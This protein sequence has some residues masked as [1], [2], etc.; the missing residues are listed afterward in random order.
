MLLR[1]NHFNQGIFFIIFSGFHWLLTFSLLFSA[2]IMEFCSKDYCFTFWAWGFY[3]SYNL[4]FVDRGMS[5]YQ[6]VL[7]DW[8][9]FLYFG[10]L[11]FLFIS[12]VFPSAAGS[13]VPKACVGWSIACTAECYSNNFSSEA[14]MP[15][16]SCLFL[17]VQDIIV[18]FL[19]NSTVGPCYKWILVL[20]LLIRQYL[21]DPSSATSSFMISICRL[22][23]RNSRC[24]GWLDVC[25]K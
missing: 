1:N 15:F 25:W 12:E 21:N 22:K 14:S 2:T 18:Q 6:N 16:F 17:N 24:Q 3:F 5:S 10:H 4:H 11:H 8:C 23:I 19:E 9:W 7:D 20:V 13:G